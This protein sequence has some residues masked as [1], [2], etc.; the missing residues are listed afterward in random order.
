MGYCDDSIQRKGLWRIIG[1]LLATL[2]L[3]ISPDDLAACDEHGWEWARPQ[4]SNA[5]GMDR[6]FRYVVWTGKEMLAWNE[7]SNVGGNYTAYL[8]GRAYNPAANSWRSFPG[9]EPLGIRSLAT[10]IWTGEEMLVWG[11]DDYSRESAKD[12]NTGGAFNPETNTWRSLSTTGAPL[13]RSWHLSLWTPVGMVVWGGMR[14]YEDINSGGIYNPDTDSWESINPLGA[15]SA[16]RDPAAVFYNGE[17]ILWGGHAMEVPNWY[18]VRLVM[19][20]ELARYNPET[21]QWSSSIA[22]GTPQLPEEAMW[23]ENFSYLIEG[24]MYVWGFANYPVT[25]GFI[26][27]PSSHSWSRTASTPNLEREKPGEPCVIWTDYEIIMWD[28]W[29]HAAH[30]NPVTN[31][32]KT[33]AFFGH[34]AVYLDDLNRAHN[35][36]HRYLWTGEEVLTWQVDE[37]LFS[38]RPQ[39]LNL[40]RR[41]LLGSAKLHPGHW[42]ESPWLGWFH[43]LPFPWI[44]H[45]EHQWIYAVP[46]GDG[47]AGL[48]DSALGWL[49]TKAEL[50]PFIY[51]MR[52]GSWLYYSIGSSNPRWF[53]NYTA[54]N[55]TSVY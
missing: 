43:D 40:E 12:L 3:G 39:C 48:H 36:L 17:L 42:V 16:R 1:P 33:G 9:Y 25:E 41:S 35:F 44:Y 38:Y 32:W 50:Y 15:P 26:Y 45:L 34:P 37:G 52:S 47:W 21:R 53:Y 14:D 5:P 4:A 49:L 24:K 7:S 2:Y 31:Q 51:D 13:G 30:Y 23:G 22:P 28:P 20:R 54:G 55:W 11:G 6:N 18:T 46:A 10:P 19:P 8:N 27:N 29:G